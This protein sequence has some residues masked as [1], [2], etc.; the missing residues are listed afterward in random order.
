MNKMTQRLTFLFLFVW[1]CSIGIFAQTAT[2]G[3]FV[4]VDINADGIQAANDPGLSGVTLRLFTD[5]NADGIP[6]TPGT[7]LA[8]T[9]SAADGTYQ[10]A[11]LAPGLY[12]VQ[13]VE[14]PGYDYTVLGI[15]SVGNPTSGFSPTINLVSGETDFTIDFG[16]YQN[17]TLGNYV[18]EDLDANGQQSLNEPGING[19]TVRLYQDSDGNGVPDGPALT[20]T[21]TNGSGLYQF[22]N[23]T[24][25]GY[26]AGAVKPNG[27]F[28]TPQ[29]TTEEFD[30]DGDPI[31]GFTQTIQISSGEY[32]G[33]NDFGFYLPGSL[34]D[35]VWHDLDADGIQESGEPGL[36]GV[37]VNLFQDVNGDGIP[38]TPVPVAQTATNG[39]GF[40]QF[41]SLTP[42]RYIAGVVQPPGYVATKQEALGGGADP[43]G[44]NGHPITGFSASIS[45]VSGENDPTVDFGFYQY[46]SIGDFVWHD[47][48]ADGLQDVGEPGLNAV[49][50][51]LYHDSNGDGI[52]D[53]APV[54]TTMTNTAGTYQFSNLMPRR[55]IV[56]AVQPIGYL[57]SPQNVAA[58]LDSDGNPITGYTES[59]HITSGEHDTSYDFGLYQ[60]GAIGNFVWHDLN[61]NGLQDA[62]EPGLGGHTIE[63]YQDLNADGQPELPMLSSKTSALNGQYQFSNLPAGNYILRFVPSSGFVA[64]AP[65]LSPFGLTTTINLLSGQVNTT[66]DFGLI[67]C[68]TEFDAAVTNSQ[69]QQSTGAIALTD[70]QL[71]GT[72]TF[73]WSNSDNAQNISNLP[74]GLYTVTVSSS[75]GCVVSKTFA[76]GNSDGPAL[77]ADITI[78]TCLPNSSGS[79]V[80]NVTGGTGSY[81]YLWST[82]ATTASI[83]NLQPGSYTVTVTDANNCA[84]IG[85]Y[86]VGF[87]APIFKVESIQ[88]TCAG[89]SNGSIYVLGIEPGGPFIYNWSHIAG[90][91]NAAAQ[92]G[93]PVGS[94][95]VT[96]TNALGCSDAS[97]YDIALSPGIGSSI[98]FSYSKDCNIFNDTLTAYGSGGVPPYTYSWSNGTAI[99][100]FTG[101]TPGSYTVTVEDANTCTSTATAFVTDLT[102]PLLTL[103]STPTLCGSTTGSVAGMGSGG[104]LPYEYV[105]NTSTL[106]NLPNGLY[107]CTLTDAAGCT[108]TNDVIVLNTD[109]P[110]TATQI[111]PISCTGNPPGYVT[112]ASPSAGDTYLWSD[113]SSN[114]TLFIATPGIYTVTVT[115]AAGCSNVSETELPN[116][117]GYCSKIGG[118]LWHDINYNGQMDPGEPGMANMQVSIYKEGSFYGLAITDNNGQFERGGLGPD[119]YFLRIMP[120]A[121]YVST[122]NSISGIGFTGLQTSLFA[123]QAFQDRLDFNM[124]YFLGNTVYGTV[125]FDPEDNCVLNGTESPMPNAALVMDGVI[126]DYYGWT[127]ANG[128]YSIPVL[129]GTYTLRLAVPPNLQVVC[130]NNIPVILNTPQGTIGQDFLVKSLICPNLEVSLTS[131]L[132]RRCF[133]SNYHWVHYTNNGPIP[134]ENA[135]IDIQLD[136]FLTLLY[137]NHPSYAS[138]GGNKYRFD[139]GDLAPYATGTFYL[140]MNLSCDAQ[141]GQTHCSTAEIF[142]INPD[143]GNL[144]TLWSG[145]L[146]EASAICEPDSLHFLL[147]NTGTGGMSGQLEYVIIEDGIMGFAQTAAPLAVGGSHE[148]ALPANGSTW[149]LEAKQEPFAPTLDRPMLSVEGCTNGSQFSIGY[150]TPFQNS[151]SDPNIDIECVENVAGADPNDKIGYPLGFGEYHQI[152]PNTPIE[153]RIR[154]Q[155]TGNDTTFNVVLRDTLSPWLDPLTIRPI[156]AS[157]PF[158]FDLDGSGVAVF[159]FDNILLPDSSTNLEASQ[160]Y[161]RFDIWP[162]PDAPLGTDIFNS[163]AI[164][165]DFNA[166]VITNTSQHRIGVDFVPMVPVWEPV[167]PGYT[168]TAVPNPTHGRTLV[169]VAGLGS[170]A[171][172]Y[173]LRLT[174]ALGRTVLDQSGSNAAFEIE[175]GHL[176]R[177]LYLLQVLD[178]GALVGSGRLIKL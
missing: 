63:L 64:I 29:N 173:H 6:D 163:A 7:P 139:L 145:A 91:N 103:S 146:V 144:N 178:G 101:L 148:I 38:D 18:W 88:N 17:G 10:F 175:T 128:Q 43:L 4:W 125:R 5:A 79:I 81:A 37:T 23:L 155:N 40:Y 54:A 154:F 71:P 162:R 15:G 24:P 130:A 176:P 2:I 66:L 113:I 116:P 141:L 72:L 16:F 171:G 161:V 8:T 177:G 34:G 152:Y 85:Q 151:D 1:T 68:D 84:A 153:Y 100:S 51:N 44:S 134:V 150:V 119:T 49:T 109:G 53:G 76:V 102:L 20:Q 159:Y 135:Y 97:T 107:A 46:G 93:L 136:P 35:Y 122:S 83:N 62:G 59:I 21:V 104:K 127:D 42:G 131:S 158:R 106:D 11:E 12:L 142:P 111:G 28:A 32:D 67:E 94:Y 78:P 65:N 166:P 149:R 41:T 160:G 132:F 27:Y 82:T 157:H 170:T 48:D 112:V 156:V 30:S 95:T 31:T 117:A 14:P 96:V 115:N 147:E 25:G 121:G 47:L 33:T 56:A 13:A 108:N 26:I 98:T 138:L 90:T 9:S 123:L 99:Q 174:D 172:N 52:P 69:C 114:D 50:V 140:W 143:C 89:M 75:N 124:G 105:W 129:P 70:I 39:S 92:F 169:R 74:M 168:L 36:E 57:F 120:P 126:N 55:Y 60:N 87:A 19:V 45:I 58:E 164:Y 22:S 3:N 167:R 61:N 73:N 133:N 165:F 86:V 137:C 118:V 110:P 80:L 77:D